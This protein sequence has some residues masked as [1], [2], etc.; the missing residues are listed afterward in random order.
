MQTPIKLRLTS[1]PCYIIFLWEK[2]FVLHFG[3]MTSAA[4]YEAAAL[5]EQESDLRW[6]ISLHSLL[7]TE[8]NTH[9]CIPILWEINITYCLF[10]IFQ[11]GKRHMDTMITLTLFR[12]WIDQAEILSPVNL[13]AE[14]IIFPSYIEG[15]RKNRKSCWKWQNEQKVLLQNI[16]LISKRASL[17]YFFLCLVTSCLC[18]CSSLFCLSLLLPFP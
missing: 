5:W 3:E 13:W 17:F 16:N 18:L 6:P 12:H 10:H 8:F 1:I 15:N 9:H 11:L 2:M 14:R 7:Q 4:I